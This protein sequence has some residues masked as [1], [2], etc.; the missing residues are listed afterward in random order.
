MK[1]NS[2]KSLSWRIVF[3][4][5]LF[6]VDLLLFFLRRRREGPIRREEEIEEEEEEEASS[7]LTFH[8]LHPSISPRLGQTNCYGRLRRRRRR[9]KRPPEETG[10]IE[11]MGRNLGALV[12]VAAPS[13][14]EGESPLRGQDFFFPSKR[15]SRW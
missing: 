2:G 3:F 7:P 14:K 5:P 8:S 10:E 15:V 11:G 6:L 13:K 12:C 4:E 9:R 1:S